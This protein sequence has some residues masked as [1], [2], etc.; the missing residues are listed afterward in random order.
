MLPVESFN[1]GSSFVRFLAENKSKKQ[2]AE[3]E[4][5]NDSEKS[6]AEREQEKGI[7]SGDI[8][9]L[10]VPFGDAKDDK[11]MPFFDVEPN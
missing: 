3:K 8:F 5:G 9:S 1:V 11:T 7:K 10:S 2:A 4:D 6:S